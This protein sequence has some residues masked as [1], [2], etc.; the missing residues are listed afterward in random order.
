MQGGWCVLEKI[1]ALFTMHELLVEFADFPIVKH[2]V[3]DTDPKISKSAEDHI[4]KIKHDLDDCTQK[5][6]ASILEKRNLKIE[7]IEDTLVIH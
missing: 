3:L 4:I 1:E 5:R 7:K 2:I 6:I